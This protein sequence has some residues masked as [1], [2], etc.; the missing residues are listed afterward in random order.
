MWFTRPQRATHPALWGKRYGFEHCHGRVKRAFGCSY[1]K[2]PRFPVGYSSLLGRC[3]RLVSYAN[4][5]LP[6][7]RLCPFHGGSSMPSLC[8]HI[9]DNSVAV[10]QCQ[11]PAAN[12]RG[13]GDVRPSRLLDLLSLTKRRRLDRSCEPLRARCRLHS[14]CSHSSVSRPSHAAGNKQNAAQWRG[15]NVYEQSEKQR[16]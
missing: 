11:I 15:Y 4:G 7:L 13:R 14:R 8:Y 16:A 9:A 3:L 1:L 10:L 5:A 6:S 2:I 12:N